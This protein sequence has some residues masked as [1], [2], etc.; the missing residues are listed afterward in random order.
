MRTTPPSM[1]EICPQFAQEEEAAD[2]LFK[3]LC[4]DSRQR[5]SIRDALAH[6]F[7]YEYYDLA[8]R[9]PLEQE[10]DAG[11][12]FDVLPSMTLD[13][14]VDES[15]PLLS[16]AA[17]SKWTDQIKSLWWQDFYRRDP[18]LPPVYPGH[19]EFVAEMVSAVAVHTCSCIDLF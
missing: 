6:P 17:F 19:V 12:Q 5:I 11:F 15:D 10:Q 14:L 9:E 8:D 1:A 4:L 7:F 16:G 13:G 18:N 3:M 2:L